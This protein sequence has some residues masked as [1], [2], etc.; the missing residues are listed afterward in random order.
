MQYIIIF[1][2]NSISILVFLVFSVP[3]CLCG[4]NSYLKI[5]QGGFHVLAEFLQGFR[6][7]DAGEHHRL[8]GFL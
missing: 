3:L 2:Y 6:G 4:S 7:F 1:I 5:D 8:E